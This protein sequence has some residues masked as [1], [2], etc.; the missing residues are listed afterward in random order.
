MS[1]QDQIK[2][3]TKAMPPVAAF[4]TLK[5]KVLTLP[6]ELI[7]I[8]FLQ[9]VNTALEAIKKDLPIEPVQIKDGY[10]CPHC[11]EPIS[12]G[13]KRCMECGQTID[14]EDTENGE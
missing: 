13:Q 8:E 1:R 4:Y 7:D 3:Q 5:M 9:C 12:S 14:W 11:D 6:R 2:E 10:K